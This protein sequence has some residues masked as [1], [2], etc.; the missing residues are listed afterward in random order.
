M[1]EPLKIIEEVV[2]Q[3]V[4]EGVVQHGH[5]YCFATSELVQY[6]LAQQ[7]IN[8]HLVEVELTMLRR[9]P[10]GIKLVG[11]DDGP[12]G[13]NSLASHMVTVTETEPPY[14]IDL[15]LG[16]QM[17]LEMRQQE[18]DV[19]ATSDDGNVK[20]IYKEKPYPKYPEITHRNILARIE[21]D[22]RQ[23][24]T[25]TWLKRLLTIVLLVSSFNFAV[26]MW[27]TYQVWVN[28]DNYWGPDTLRQLDEK[29]D[30]VNRQLEPDQ[31]RKRM[32]DAGVVVKP[33]K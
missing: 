1:K 12:A 7:G 16:A 31:L 3:L 22:R 5:N 13:S 14:L 29:I 23:Q 4:R 30:R 17:V 24:T 8:S 33:T 28:P 10:P 25:I 18:H 6:M 32:E 26:R 20:M 2:A 9:T 27:D 21:Q 19:I 15:S 11:S